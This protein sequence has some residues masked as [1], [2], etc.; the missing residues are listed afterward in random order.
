MKKWSNRS[1]RFFVLILAIWLI[2]SKFVLAQVAATAI[3]D[4]NI[5]SLQVFKGD[6]QFHYPILELD[7]DEAFTIHFDDFS[8]P[9]NTYIYTITFCNADWTPSDLLKSDFLSGF[10]E[11]M[12]SA[13]E[14]SSNTSKQYAHYQLSLPNDDV[15]FLLPGNY[16]LTVYKNYRPDS[17]IFTQQLYIFSNILETIAQMV[18]PLETSKILSHQQ[19]NIEINDVENL[20]RDV[21][22][23]VQII[24]MQNFRPDKLN[25]LKEPTFI[26]GNK[27]IYQNKPENL[28]AG[29]TEFLHFDLKS[30]RF[31]EMRTDSITFDGFFY[32]FYIQADELLPYK[33]YTSAEDLNGNYKIQLQNQTNSMLLADYVYVHLFV[34]NN[35][36][37]MNH[38]LFAIGQ[39]NFWQKS[40]D[41]SYKWNS[42]LHLFEKVFFLKQG[43]YNYLV[44]NRQAQNV[45]SPLENH[46][47]TENEYFIFVYLKDKTLNFDKLAG[48]L[49]INSLS[50]AN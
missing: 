35:K 50:G 42:E 18:K 31:K 47:E 37:I 12:I 7:S 25:Q 8:Q 15:Q 5:R 28:F 48:F 17:I 14:F 33:P 23:D 16:L 29:G 49:T 39:F 46:A 6:W 41:Y 1:K 34:E 19:V 10:D 45:M 32:H 11:Q 38:Q 40:S 13:Y 9:Q 21:Y 20:I 4:Q 22:Q 44:E 3:F 27:Y 43:Y 30:I 36:Y 26:K 24:I 2:S